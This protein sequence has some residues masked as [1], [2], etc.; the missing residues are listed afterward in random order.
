[1]NHPNVPIIQI[2]LH[3][4]K[5]A[6]AILARSMA[7]AQTSIALIQEP[8]LV[9]DAISG[10]GGCGTI[11][12]AQ[13]TRK[14]RTCVVTK[15][16]TATFLPQLSGD[17]LTVVLTKINLAGDRTVD[18]LIGSAYMPYDSTGLPPQEEIINLVAYAKQRGL[19]LLLGCDA[20]SHHVCWGS[21]NINPRGVSLHDFILGNE[22]T[23]LNRGT[24]PTFMD[25]RRQEV[26]DITVCTK[27]VADLVEDW[28]VSD[29]PSGSDHRQ[30]RLTLRHSVEIQWARNPRK[31]NWEGFDRDLGIMLT[32]VPNR[33]HAKDQLETAA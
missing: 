16:V 7:A 10:L 2:N 20:N 27:E 30:I 1:M 3:H 19:Q 14:L 11:H 25:S 12:K 8:W 13:P 9:R 15:G 28:R 6:S 5:S 18:L 24:E 26:L 22:L 29:E 33:F 31:T 4:S 23:I 21:S 17:D 32:K